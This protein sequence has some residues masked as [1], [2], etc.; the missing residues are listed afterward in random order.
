MFE[1]KAPYE[2]VKRPVLLKVRAPLD[3]YLTIV[4]RG[5]DAF[6]A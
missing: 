4:D 1:T 6:G 5:L 2:T 3:N